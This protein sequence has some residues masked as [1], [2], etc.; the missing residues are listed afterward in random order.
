V[1]G[2][3]GRYR[4]VEP[5]G[6]GGM[7]VV[8]S[9]RLDDGA[10]VAI[11]LLTSAR[12]RQPRFR[13]SFRREAGAIARLDHPGI[14]GV[15]DLGEVGPGEGSEEIPD[16]SPYLVMDLVRGASLHHHRGQLGWS[17]LREALLV[18]LGALAHA[19]SRGLVNPALK[20]SNVVVEGSGV[21]LTDFGVARAAD[22]GGWGPNE[23][24]AGGTPSYMAPELLD[25][26]WRDVGPWTDLYG[27]GCL[28]WSLAAGRPPF[29][30]SNR[31]ETMAAQLTDALPAFDPLHPVPP[32]FLPWLERLLIKRA[33]A[34]YQRAADAAWALLAL[35]Q[36]VDGQ[37]RGASVAPG[38][39]LPRTT[40]FWTDA[41]LPQTPAMAP[42]RRTRS[43]RPRRPLSPPLAHAPVPGSWR[44]LPPLGGTVRRLAGTGLGLVGVRQVPLVGRD[45]VRDVLWQ[46]LR[47]AAGG[48]AQAVVLTGPAGLGQGRLARWLAE[49]AHEVG[50]AELA[51]AHGQPGSGGSVPRMLERALV[52]DDLDRDALA[53]RLDR[54]APDRTADDRA[55]LVELLRPSLLG[56]FLR[57]ASAEA[58][59]ALTTRWLRFLAR[60]RVLLL[61]VD[62]AAH[63]AD[64]LE[65][66]RHVLDRRP[67]L[68]MVAVVSTS[69]DALQSRADERELVQA[70]GDHE[71]GRRCSLG[72]LPDHWME[73]LVQELLGLEPGLGQELVQ[74]AGGNPRFAVEVIRDAAAHGRLVPTEHGYRLAD[75][76]ALQLPEDV[77]A[78]WALAV[79]RALT[80]HASRQVAELGAV[81]GQQVLLAEWRRA[82]RVAG[83]PDPSPVA[84]A[85]VE[86]RL[87][88]PELGWYRFVHSLVREAL[89]TSAE[90]SGRL[91]EHHRVCVDALRGSVR[92][93]PARLGPHLVGAGDHQAGAEA[94]LQ[95]AER[96]LMAAAFREAR[97]LL[98]QREQVLDTLEVADDAAQ[99]VEGWRLLARCYQESGQPAMASETLQRVGRAGADPGVL[100]GSVALDL[101]DYETAELAF[102]AHVDD[103]PVAAWLGLASLEAQ[104]EGGAE[105]LAYTERAYEAAAARGDRLGLARAV[106]QRAACHLGRGDWA[107]ALTALAEAADRFELLGHRRGVARCTL[108]LGMAARLAGQRQR[109]EGAFRDALD[110][111]VKLGDPLGELRCVNGL[112][113][114][115]R[116]RGDLVQAE[117]SYRRA[118]ELAE[119][120]DLEG[121]GVIP[122][123]NLAL[124]LMEQERADDAQWAL[125]SVAAQLASQRRLALLGVVQ[126]VRAAAAAMRGDQEEA[127][128]LLGEGERLLEQTGRVEPDVARWAER[129]AEHLADDAAVHRARALAER[130][131]SRLGAAGEDG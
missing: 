20:A 41:E 109:T 123:V 55:G 16:G 48:S 54:I 53:A 78:T 51:V 14:V 95:G 28:A 105:A 108:Q 117:R 45:E 32:G 1:A 13:H 87:M 9:A 96:A 130:Q 15:H 128:V 36:Q 35:P 21:R 93:G 76:Q 97:G 50:A 68:P 52:A 38:D 5:I 107:S 72:P 127:V 64:A 122:T 70:L 47:T 58:Q 31:M 110:H 27:L 10:F 11:K 82:C 49:R 83:L 118:I 23:L 79:E 6:R 131:R 29:A 103:E 57:Y 113:E 34:R 44:S 2:R 60:R 66:V 18:L 111:F 77:R 8:W 61:W 75:G 74:R 125:D 86:C 116:D 39:E 89:V 88:E 106:A 104:R 129:A 94:L 43:G 26:A 12:A 19:H 4:L 22:P 100:A 126:V 25:G 124:V 119:R 37:P 30:R 112:G 56:G 101:G 40:V 102:R 67:E 42:S 63:A 99:R 85:L 69:D 62:D 17:R 46:A 65:L 90:D 121:Q 81:L 120:C 115:A 114:L 33:D 80:A 3:L 92:G 7:G 98:Q 71:R 73:Q 91:A 84:D 24:P 59:R